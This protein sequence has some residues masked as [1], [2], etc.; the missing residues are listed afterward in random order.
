MRA[1]WDW[2]WREK[3]VP[4]TSIVMH[5]RQTASKGEAHSASLCQG[6]R[7]PLGLSAYLKDLED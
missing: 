3:P 6:Q 4:N 2:R 7:C 5:E 1:E